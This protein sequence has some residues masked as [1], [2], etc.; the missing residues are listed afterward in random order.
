MP[1]DMMQVV[2]AAMGESM[3]GGSPSHLGGSGDFPRENLG[4]C[5]AEKRF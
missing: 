3:R 1:E 2:L 4:N 5:G